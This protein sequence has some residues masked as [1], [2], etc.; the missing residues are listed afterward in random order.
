M[1]NHTS[2]IIV[3]RSYYEP[4]LDGTQ[5]TIYIKEFLF[6]DTSCRRYCVGFLKKQPYIT[7]VTEH[8]PHFFDNVAKAYCGKDLYELYHSEGIDAVPMSYY[9]MP[10]RH[11]YRYLKEFCV[12]YNISCDENSFVYAI[13]TNTGSITYNSH[14]IPLYIPK[15]PPHSASPSPSPSSSDLYKITYYHSSDDEDYM[16]N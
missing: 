11:K 8:Q 3:M 12:V 15:V 7:E 10:Y 16:I 6:K 5:D 13:Q 2:C 14:C 4:Y 9:N 1:K